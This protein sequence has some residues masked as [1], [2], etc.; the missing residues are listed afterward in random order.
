[1]VDIAGNPRQAQ[2]LLKVWGVGDRIVAVGENG[3]IAEYMDGAWQVV[4]TGSEAT[5]SFV[6]VWGTGPDDLVA[7]GGNSR[8]QVATS[9]GPGQW[10][11]TR[12]PDQPALNGSFV[13]QPGLAIVVGLEGFLGRYEMDTGELVREPG[14][15][16]FR[17]HSV[18]GDGAGRYYG[19][20][21]TFFPPHEGE[22]FVRVVE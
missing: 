8:A 4:S 3:T 11:T 13:D 20:G 10:E 1:M 22:A 2:A 7:V 18:W 21:G 5:E 6:S 19:V 15:A 14:G 17:L 9:D 12:F 16:I